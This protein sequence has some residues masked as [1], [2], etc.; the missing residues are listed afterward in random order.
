MIEFILAHPY[1]TIWVS[2]ILMFER[3]MY[4]GYVVDD[5]DTTKVMKVKKERFK[6]KKNWNIHFF[7]DFFHHCYYS[8]G[9][10]RNEKQEHL[11]TI[12]LHGVNC[13]LIYRMTGSLL[14]TLLLPLLNAL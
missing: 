2:L 14:A 6:D 13:S 4:C 5:Q 3:A 1:L 10:F 12:I 7:L 9:I 8:C 11:F